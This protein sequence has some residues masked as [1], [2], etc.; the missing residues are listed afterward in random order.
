MNFILDLDNT[1][2]C[3]IP[4]YD[5]ANIDI[6]VEMR[7]QFTLF[8]PNR[9]ISY[10]TKMYARPWLEPFLRDL[11]SNGTITVW[12]GAQKNYAEHAIKELF[13]KDIPIKNVLSNYYTNKLLV[14]QK[15][16]KPLEQLSIDCPEYK[17]DSTIIIDDDLMVIEANPNNS[18]LINTFTKQS[19]LSNK[20][21]NELEIVLEKIKNHSIYNSL[22]ST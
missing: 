14:K 9:S 1:L 4:Y 11:A 3:A 20:L 15:K 5:T 2:L 18:I 10:I 13:P 19:I 22:K 6:Y 16:L 21:D 8:Q 12:T 17:M 7:Y